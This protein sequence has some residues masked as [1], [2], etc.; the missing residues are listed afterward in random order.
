M[1]LSQAQLPLA[2]RSREQG[3]QMSPR[4]H[5]PGGAALGAIRD[6]GTK[7]GCC[8]QRGLILELR[9]ERGALGG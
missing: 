2:N 8:G 9:P 1:A 4:G 6:G 7:G 3:R 5:W